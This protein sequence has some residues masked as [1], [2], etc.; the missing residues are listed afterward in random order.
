MIE[1]S[2]D[3]DVHILS[4][5]MGENR[6]DAD[7]FRTLHGALDEVDAES[8]GDSALVL[9]GEGKYFSN[10][11]N[12]TALE[13]LATAERKAVGVDLMRCMG[14]VLVLRVPTVAAV[15]GH[16]FAGGAL[17]AAACDYR[18]MRE[19]RGWICVAEVDVGVPIDPALIA[20]LAAKLT[21]AT[22]R[23]SVLEGRRYTAAEGLAAG[24]V[25]A[26]APDADL[27]SVASKQAAQLASKGRRIYG[28]LKRSLWGDVARQLG[29]ESSR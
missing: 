11:L 7:F 4:M 12:L 1:H 27:L 29:Y 3:G 21:P 17:L 9:T 19:D 28:S 2:R 6:M 22:L 20:L 10:G 23:S 14:R 25:D 16:A 18:V 15:N 24:W 26:T 13:K 5:R 8:D